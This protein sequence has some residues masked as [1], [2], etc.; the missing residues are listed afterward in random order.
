[1][2]VQRITLAAT[3]VPLQQLR[4][5]KSRHNLDRRADQRVVRRGGKQ[6]EWAL[7]PTTTD[8]FFFLKSGAPLKTSKQNSFRDHLFLS[9]FDEGKKQLPHTAMQIFVKTLTGTLP[10]LRLTRRPHVLLRSF[11]SVLL[12]SAFLA[13]SW[14]K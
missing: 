12:R 7:F 9:R 14:A 2:K 10:P 5:L 13:S 3:S 4:R 6:N 8:P 1:M 11:R